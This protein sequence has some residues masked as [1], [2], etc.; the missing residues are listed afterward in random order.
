MKKGFTIEDTVKAIDLCKEVGLEVGGNFILG[1]PHETEENINKTISFAKSLPI[2]TANFAIMVPFPGTE[3]REMAKKNIGGMKLLTDDWQVY[4]KQIG[5]TLE[6]EQLPQKE[7][8]RLQAKA[9]MN[10][11]LSP[12]R[13]IYFLKGLNWNRFVY[14]VKR[15]VEILAPWN[16][17]A[18]THTQ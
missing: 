2:D 11:Y 15:A 18:G 12:R 8:L 1:F 6:L 4:G 10:F 5:K 14:A 16:R 9:Y 7:L 3:I 13:F 17:A